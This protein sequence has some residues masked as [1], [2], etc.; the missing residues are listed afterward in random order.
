MRILVSGGAGLIGSHLCEYLLELGN[1]VICVDNFFS[2]HK[3]NINH[4]IES[5]SFQLIEH[6]IIDPLFFDVDQIYNLA[7]P[8]SPVHYQL[9]PVNTMK[10]SVYGAINMLELAKNTKS[11]ILQ[12]STSEIY[13]DPNIH[14]QKE[15]YWGNVNPIGIRSC[16]DEGKRAAE[17]LFFDYKRQFD[18]D[19]RVVRIF[20]TYGPRMAINDGRVISNFVTQAL[21]NEN[22]TVYGDGNQTRSF[23]YIND[24]II[25]LVS[26]ME[27]DEFIGPLNLG[28]PNDKRI[29]D[30]AKEIILISKSKSEIQFSDLPKDDPLQRRPDISLAIKKLNWHPKTSFIQGIDSTIKYFNKII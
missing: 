19:I 6:D 24:L 3:K 8:A 15:D 16:Y 30:V 2:G 29:I 4:L 12:A 20:N 1:E 5:E 17:T 18:L 21:K 13:G 25:G 26:M 7:C 9:D 11:R 27:N 22:I 23:C 10:T 14:P 28:N